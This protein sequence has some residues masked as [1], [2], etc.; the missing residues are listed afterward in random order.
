MTSRRSLTSYWQHCVTLTIEHGLVLHGEALVVS[1]SERERI[2]HQLHQFYKG[3]TKSQL[4]TCGCIFWS[5]INKA[6]EEV[7]YQCETCT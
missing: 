7:L 4:L 1:P 3:I 2:L 6:I 5:G